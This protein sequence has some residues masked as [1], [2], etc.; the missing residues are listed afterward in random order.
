MAVSQR[1]TSSRFPYLPIHLWVRQR[2]DQVE[3][4][5]DTGFDGDVALPPEAITDGDRPDGY[6]PWTLADGS[7]VLAP[8]Y[9]SSAQV[10]TMPSFSAVII[11]L[12][13]EPLVGRGVSDR[14]SIILDHGQRLIVEP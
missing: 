5:L 3:A 12:G 8:A 7:E 10:G 4:L 2:S 14:F 1:V 6:L 13:E 9:R 11:A